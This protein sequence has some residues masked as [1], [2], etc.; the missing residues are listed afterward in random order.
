[1]FRFCS[2]L[3]IPALFLAT[4]ATAQ[5]AADSKKAS[6]PPMEAEVRFTDGSIVRMS[7][8]QS[9]I[10]VQ[11]KYGKLSVPTSDI[12]KID[13]G[14]HVDADTEK[15]IAQAIDDLASDNYRMRERALG[16]LVSFGPQAFPQ[17]NRALQ[18]EQ[19]E[20]MKRAAL[21]MDKIKAKHPVR[22]L[23]LREEDIIATSAFTIVGKVT[24]STLK[25]K[26]ENFGELEIK[27]PKLRQIHWLNSAHD[28]E[29]NVDAGRYGSAVNQ[30][31]DSGFEARSGMRLSIVASGSVNIWP[32]SPGYS[33]TPKGYA[34]AGLSGGG[35]A[36]QQYAAGA[37][38]GRIGEDGPPFLIGESCE[39][40]SSR[41][42]KIYLHIV[43]S[44]W[45][46]AST[47][48]YQVRITQKI[49]M[50]EGN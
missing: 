18:S 4:L 33:C 1:M 39:I 3:S 42:G 6:D 29:I 15:K 13:F 30:W 44:P 23:R 41:D 17:V 24:T 46:N 12:Y 11:T 8:L 28:A 25:A 50:P 27:L 19:L 22:N 26:S 10:E 37:L 7:I 32:Q 40:A 21:A 20:V 2:W 36:N 16:E 47:G 31:M 49:E 14:V 9:H 38:I 43:P 48:S 35:S 45:N 5:Q 34:T